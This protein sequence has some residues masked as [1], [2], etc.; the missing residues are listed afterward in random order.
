MYIKQP[1]F[2]GIIQ[3]IVFVKPKKPNS[4]NRRCVLIKKT[5]KAK[6]KEQTVFK[7]VSVRGNNNTNISIYNSALFE[8]KVYADIPG[9]KFR[10]KNT[11][12]MINSRSKYGCKN[13]YNLYQKRYHVCSCMSCLPY[14]VPRDQ[15]MNKVME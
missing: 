15:L 2:R 14:L 10:L 3:S 6:C 1:Q 11:C 7:L 12:P 8:Y 4:G 13:I 5:I 9:V